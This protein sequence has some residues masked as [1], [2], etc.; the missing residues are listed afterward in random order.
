MHTSDVCVYLYVYVYIFMYLDLSDNV[1]LSPF[2]WP[3]PTPI[4]LVK[5]CM[6]ELSTKK[7]LTAGPSLLQTMKSPQ[8]IFNMQ[9]KY[10]DDNYAYP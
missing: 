4:S 1:P 8:E 9:K 2:P 6:Q 7:W 3:P 10:H 5:L